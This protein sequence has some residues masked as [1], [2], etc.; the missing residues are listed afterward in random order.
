MRKSIFILALSASLAAVS[1]AACGGDSSSSTPTSAP[2]AAATAAPTATPTAVVAATDLISTKATPANSLD[3]ADPAWKNARVTTVKT[4]V[5]KG[6]AGVAGVDVKMQAL[7]S[8]T[9]VWFRFEYAAP[10]MT[11]AKDWVYDGAKFKAPSGQG[12]RLGLMWEIKPS[13]DFEA[14]GCAA[15]CHNPETDKVA[16]WYMVSPTGSLMDLWQWTVGTSNGFKQAGDYTFTD[17]VPE[18]TALGSV[19]VADANTGGGNVANTNDTKDAPIKM[20]DPAKKPSLG[21]QYLL[22][23]EAVALDVTKLK[24][25]DK[26]PNAI[27]EPFK[28]DRGDVDAFGTWANGTYTI[29]FHRNMDTGNAATDVKFAAGGL[30]KFGLGVWIALGNVDHT[31]STEAYTVKFAK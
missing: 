28:G 4:S 27:L 6:S 24:A 9:D 5:V 25:G 11:T 10:A 17:K 18:P 23:S 7:N 13:T 31:V 12:D 14:K 1:I 15:L 26:I 19:F 2:T 16:Q 8:D 21:P 30:Y 3:A 20:Q 22:V 29:V